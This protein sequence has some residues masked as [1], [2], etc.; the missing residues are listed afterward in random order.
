MSGNTGIPAG[1]WITVVLAAAV[2]LIV[3]GSAV[4]SLWLREAPIARRHPPSATSVPMV[5]SAPLRQAAAARRA[6]QLAEFRG[7]SAAQVSKADGFVQQLRF[8]EAEDAYMDALEMLKGDEASILPAEE[9]KDSVR[10]VGEKIRDMMNHQVLRKAMEAVDEA[11]RRGDRIGWTNP[12]KGWVRKVDPNDPELRQEIRD[13][14]SHLAM[15]RGRELKATGRLAQARKAFEMGLKL[16]A[17]SKE[18][19]AELEELNRAEL[20]LLVPEGDALFASGD[21]AGAMM[22][23]RRVQEL[24][25]L[26]SPDTLPAKVAECLFRI[27]VAQAEGFRRRKQYAEAE[28]AYRQAGEIKPAAAALIQVWSRAMAAERA[29]TADQERPPATRAGG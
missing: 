2:A 22:K 17:N 26:G 3:A 18:T 27:K 7:R 14:I 25:P 23:Y 19:R 4:Q 28:K 11:R 21:W 15:V 12:P 10:R 13:T 6:E 8:A 1:K 20:K 5:T 24:D 16:D 29:S 9:A